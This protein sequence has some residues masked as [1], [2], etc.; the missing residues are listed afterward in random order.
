MVRWE[1]A[2][3][4]KLN[5]LLNDIDGIGPLCIVNLDPFNRQIL[6]FHKGKA[7]SLNALDGGYDVT[8]NVG[9][10]VMKPK[11]CFIVS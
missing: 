11:Y 10:C 8:Q 1:D 4:K 5:S 3:D 2:S 6:V 9:Q 7:R